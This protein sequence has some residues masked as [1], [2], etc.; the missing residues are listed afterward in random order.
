[1]DPSDHTLNV[2]ATLPRK[3]LTATGSA[4][5]TVTEKTVSLTTHSVN[6]PPQS[7]S[8]IKA[9]SSNP[10]GSLFTLVGLIFNNQWTKVFQ[11]AHRLKFNKG[12]S[13]VRNVEKGRI[14]SEYSKSKDA[15]HS[16]QWEAP[17]QAGSFYPCP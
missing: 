7:V 3:D 9:A 14:R 12:F 2:L 5:W 8:Y 6:R 17:G 10:E 11:N 16:C 4:P 1:M 15:W 13:G